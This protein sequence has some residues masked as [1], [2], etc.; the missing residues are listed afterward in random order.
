[1]CDTASFKPCRRQDL[2]DCGGPHKTTLMLIEHSPNCH[3]PKENPSEMIDYSSCCPSSKLGVMGDTHDVAGGEFWIAPGQ[4]LE[5]MSD[6]MC[7]HHGD[8]HRHRPV[9]LDELPTGQVQL[10]DGRH[11]IANDLRVLRRGTE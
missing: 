1:M 7:K 11:C 6:L 9:E 8:E 10:S 5:L 2:P 4:R 3:N